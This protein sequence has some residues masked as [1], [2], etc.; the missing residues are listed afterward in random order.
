MADENTNLFIAL[1]VCLNNLSI[2]ILEVKEKNGKK[3]YQVSKSSDM[4]TLWKNYF[5]EEMVR[6]TVAPN[7]RDQLD[8]PNRDSISQWMKGTVSDKNIATILGNYIPEFSVTQGHNTINDQG[9]HL[10]YLIE[11]SVRFENSRDLNKWFFEEDLRSRDSLVTEIYNKFNRL[12]EFFEGLPLQLMEEKYKWFQ[13]TVKNRIPDINSDETERTFASIFSAML[14]LALNIHD[15]KGKIPEDKTKKVEDNIENYLCSLLGV[16]KTPK[17]GPESES[18]DSKKAEDEKS[19]NEAKSQDL[20]EPISAKDVVY[21]VEKRISEFAQTGID[22][23]DTSI[24]DS[25]VRYRHYLDINMFEKVLTYFKKYVKKLVDEGKKDTP[26]WMQCERAVILLG[27]REAELRLKELKESLQNE[28]LADLRDRI[29]KEKYG[30][31][32]YI[33]E[34]KLI[35]GVLT[36]RLHAKELEIMNKT[37]M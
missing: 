28:R 25:I 11:R 24:V 18:D 1:W 12:K 10:I 2:V 7:K 22:D 5:C 31:E 20:K 30:L 29:L 16:K 26:K 15:E 33:G 17:A 21:I 6:K 37:L 8:T 35:A 34:K 13:E 27:L 32:H 9:K 14:I 36:E 4:V 23:V 19:D 3:G